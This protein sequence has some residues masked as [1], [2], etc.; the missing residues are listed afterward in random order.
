MKKIAFVLLIASITT[1]FS[2]AEKRSASKGNITVTVT[3]IDEI[4]GQIVFMLF[5]QADGFPKELDKAFKK[6]YVKEFND[7]ATATFSE[8]PFGD[9]AVSVFHDQNMDG[10]IQTNFIGMP[11]EPVGASNL[12]KMGKPSYKKCVFMLNEAEIAIKLRFIL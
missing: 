2:T 6:V 1:S 11:K 3:G 7:V 8:V 12:T 4:K 5:N 10:E 9:Y